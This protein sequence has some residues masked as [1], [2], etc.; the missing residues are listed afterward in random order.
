MQRVQETMITMLNEQ[1]DIFKRIRMNCEELEAHNVRMLDYWFHEKDA[2][3]AIQYSTPMKSESAHSK[4]GSSIMDN[5]PLVG[6][7][8]LSGE[9][10]REDTDTH[11]TLQ[12]PFK[13][14]KRC[15]LE[16]STVYKPNY[17]GGPLI[18]ND[19]LQLSSFQT[20]PSVSNARGRP[21]TCPYGPKRRIGRPKKTIDESIL[22]MTPPEYRS[23]DSMNVI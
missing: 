12:Y 20:P 10:H 5:S 11:I 6:C 7:I 17:F 2:Q 19:N 22:E 1:F 16:T 21:R 13:K 3:Q 18:S 9:S 23:Y 4:S 15:K 14:Q 8:D